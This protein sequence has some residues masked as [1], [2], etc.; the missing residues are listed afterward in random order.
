MKDRIALLPA[1]RRFVQRV[2]DVET[3]AAA[4]ANEVIFFESNIE[5]GHT[6]LAAC[7]HLK[8]LHAVLGNSVRCRRK[9]GA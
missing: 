8:V 2:T 6:T 7:A 9:A 1:R 3:F 4:R 5:N